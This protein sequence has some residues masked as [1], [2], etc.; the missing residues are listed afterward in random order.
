MDT[1][2]HEEQPQQ[3]VVQ[4]EQREETLALRLGLTEEQ[5]EN[6]DE[7]ITG[8]FEN[9]EFDTVDD[10]FRHCIEEE[11]SKEELMYIAHGIGCV[12]TKNHMQANPLAHLFGG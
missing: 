12:N 1:Q 4:D 10:F 9:K 2:K 5:E 6:A 7:L 11:L 3:E 8:V